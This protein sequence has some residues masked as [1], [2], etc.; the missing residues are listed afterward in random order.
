MCMKCW[1]CVSIFRCCE[2][3]SVYGHNLKDGVIFVSIAS[4]VISAVILLISIACLVQTSVSDEQINKH[5]LMA[6]N[7]IFSLVA[8]CLSFYTLII[9]VL[10]LWQARQTKVNIFI[11]SLWYVSHLSIL[12]LYCILFMAKVVV[13]FIRKRYFTAVFSAFAGILYQSI[14]VYFTIVVNIT[15]AGRKYCTS[16]F[17]KGFRL[18]RELS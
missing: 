9:S 12:T 10:L 15:V 18:C 14:F 16:T 13:C 11:C 17:R 4:V 3:E 8:F 7:L 5:P 1:R 6:V 2:V